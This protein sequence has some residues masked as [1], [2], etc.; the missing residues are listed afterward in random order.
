[1]INIDSIKEQFKKVISFSQGIDDPQVDELFNSWLNAKRD[2]IEAFDGALIKEVS[3]PVHFHLDPKVQLSNFNNFIAEIHSVY[4]NAPL[5]D[6]LNQNREG[7]YD[8]TVRYAYEGADFKIPQGMKLVK[9]FKFFEKDEQILTHIQNQASQI[10]QEDKI[11]GTL[12]FSVHPLDF[13]SISV[14]TYNWRSCHALD[15]E[16][17]AGNLSY[18]LDKSTIVC[19]LRGADNVV[20]PMFPTDVPWNSKKWR[21]LFYLSE[22][23][24][25]IFASKQYPF[26]SKVGIDAALQ[27]LL[28]MLKIDPMCFDGWKDDYCTSYIYPNGREMGF[29]TPYVP[30]QNKL[31]PLDEMVVDAD[32]RTPL[33]F[34]DVLRSSTYKRPLYAVRDHLWWYQEVNPHFTIGNRVKCLCCNESY[35]ID[36]ELMVCRDC[37]EEFNLYGEDMAVCDCCGAH[38]YEDEFVYVQGEVVC[39]RCF[40]SQCFTCESCDEY[41]FNED[42]IYDRELNEYVCVHCYNARKDNRN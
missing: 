12:C 25:M 18:M 28:P 36:S 16:F 1:M 10:I 7:F 31:L 34:N 41:Y 8:N 17:R 6:F 20:L 23:W 24:D 14:N 40:E 19:Y 3:V 33:H 37:A 21:V 30:I 26:S 5:E 35:I 32:E 11:E 42:K 29:V 27:H 15:G 4:N 38:V 13:L 39:N 2:I 22:K 9:A